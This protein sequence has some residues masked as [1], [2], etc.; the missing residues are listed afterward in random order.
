MILLYNSRL[1]L[2]P[3]K[4]RSR[5]TGPFHVIKVYDH[6]AIELVDPKSGEIF[7]VN[8]QRLKPYQD[9]IPLSEE[10][11]QFNEPIYD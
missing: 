4:L 5:W 9:L 10:L 3:G 11:V 8:G 6:G 2:F 7:K 1:H